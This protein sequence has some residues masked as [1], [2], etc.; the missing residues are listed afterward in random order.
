MP[1]LKNTQPNEIKSAYLPFIDGLRAIAVLAVLVYHFFPSLLPSGYIG[2]DVFFVISGYLISKNIFGAIHSN[3]FS[4]Q[5][6]YANRI[7]RIMPAQILIFIFVYILGMIFLSPHEFENL[8][9]SIYFSL[10]TMQN[11]I[12]KKEMGYFDISS[13][14]KPLL[15]LWS[16]AIEEQFYIL[17]PWTI[18]MIKKVRK[19]FVLPSL[20]FGF[21]I[22]FLL[23]ILFI[24]EKTVFVFYMLPTRAW[25]LLLGCVLG[26]LTIHKPQMLPRKI[27]KGLS[28]LGLIFMILAFLFCG[29]R[30]FYPG[31]WALL[32]TFATVFAIQGRNL[33]LEGLF[34]HPYLRSVGKVSYSI[35]LWHWPILSFAAIYKGGPLSSLHSLFLFLLSIFLGYINT[36]YVENFF[37]FRYSKTVSVVCMLWSLLFVLSWSSSR[38]IPKTFMELRAPYVRKISDACTD[39]QFPSDSLIFHSGLFQ[40]A[41]SYGSGKDVI[42]FWG[43]SNMQQYWP[44]I[45]HVMLQNPYLRKKYTTIWATYGGQAPFYDKESYARPEKF[46]MATVEDYQASTGYFLNHNPIKK[47]VIGASWHSYLGCTKTYKSRIKKIEKTLKMLKERDIETFLILNIPVHPS[48]NPLIYMERSPFRV[49]IQPKKYSKIDWIKASPYTKDLIKIAQKYGVRVIDPAEKI[50]P[51]MR[52]FVTEPDGNFLYKDSGHLRASYVRRHGDFMD[53]VF[54]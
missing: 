12:I 52:C 26:Y 27:E 31:W 37:R 16:L 19:S 14:Q 35:Y 41:L 29:D 48:T 53:V 24:Y 51:N 40:S 34:T 39:W 46:S 8:N 3:T 21:T 50:C 42:F 38:G 11:F 23:N 1:A 47:V 6:F 2:V 4:V 7:K 9:K 15:H 45:E 5:K 44:R 28:V 43:D 33:F 13:I 20:V 32:P 22:S 30:K 49:P 17:F 25:E 36:V 18:L 10:F 54:E